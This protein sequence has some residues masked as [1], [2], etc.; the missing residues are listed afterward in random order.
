MLKAVLST[1]HSGSSSKKRK[2]NLPSN[3]PLNPSSDFESDGSVVYKSP[4]I[5]KG[6]S[7]TAVSAASK[8]S[9]LNLPSSTPLNPSSESESDESVVD[10]IH[11]IVD[12][13]CPCIN[14][15]S[16]N[17]GKKS[18]YNAR[19]YCLYGLSELTPAL[20]RFLESH[21][22][23]FPFGG[24]ISAADKLWG[25]HFRPW[26][27]MMVFVTLFGDSPYGIAIPLLGIPSHA[28]RNV[29]RQQYQQT[30]VTRGLS[31]SPK[32]CQQQ[33]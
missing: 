30:D 33:Q 16:P 24:F 3:T 5:A 32:A 11:I 14:G 1:E 12:E 28:R 7:S 13:K 9:K 22:T 10:I 29:T 17:E 8:K 26:S 25:F 18:L 20:C 27:Q 21:T 4:T 23:N 19:Q 31:G 15:R 2:L 6:S